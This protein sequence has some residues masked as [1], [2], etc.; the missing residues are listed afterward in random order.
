VVDQGEPVIKID[1]YQMYKAEDGYRNI[2]M[3]V[4]DPAW[5]AMVHAAMEVAGYTSYG[6]NRSGEDGKITFTFVTHAM[7]SVLKER[8]M[9]SCRNSLGGIFPNKLADIIP[10]RLG[11]TQADLDRHIQLTCIPEARREYLLQGLDEVMT[12][13][14]D[15]LITVFGLDAGPAVLRGHNFDGTVEYQWLNDTTKINHVLN[16][17]RECYVY[18][19]YSR[20]TGSV[21]TTERVD[22]VPI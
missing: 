4:D 21:L 18:S 15:R 5:H 7:A 20:S 14:C 12:S 19:K 11:T 16:V 22:I 8:H 9:H 6:M 13:N 2:T 17:S 3:A 1:S 10:G